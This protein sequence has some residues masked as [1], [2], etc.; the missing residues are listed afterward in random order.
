HVDEAEIARRLAAWR[1]RRVSSPYR[2]GYAHLYVTHVLQADRGCDFDFL[3]GASG[4]DVER[5]SH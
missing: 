5:E 3:I 1:E 4:A 2:R